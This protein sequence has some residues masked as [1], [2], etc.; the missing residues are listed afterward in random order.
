MGSGT[1]HPL[2][3]IV[4][5]AEMTGQRGGLNHRI[6]RDL[7]QLNRPRLS[8]PGPP[9]HGLLFGL[10]VCC[11]RFLLRGE[12][13]SLLQAMGRSSA[14]KTGDRVAVL[15][16]IGCAFAG[17]VPALL[18]CGPAH[19][20]SAQ[21]TRQ[22]RQPPRTSPDAPAKDGVAFAGASGLPGAE[23]ITLHPRSRCIL[24]GRLGYL[25]RDRGASASFFVS[26]PRRA[27]RWN[28]FP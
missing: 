22:A 15:F 25:L 3:I 2:T 13:T 5:R 23:A 11:D 24:P 20:L 6:R 17:C 10:S 27:G 1:G 12:D 19:G 7:H 9:P 21:L 28:R 14:G 4:E 16:A 18:V 26:K 8:F